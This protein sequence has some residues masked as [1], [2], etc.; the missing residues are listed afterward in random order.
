MRLLVFTFS[1]FA[2]SCLRSC[3]RVSRELEH[4]QTSRW[5]YIL[6]SEVDARDCS[7]TERF[8]GSVSLP[9]LAGALSART[10]IRFAPMEENLAPIT[11]RT[12]AWGGLSF[13]EGVRVCRRRR[14]V[15]TSCLAVDGLQWPLLEAHDRSGATRVCDLDGF[16][17]RAK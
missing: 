12:D 13:D 17:T 7:G 2:L 4:H 8:T 9:F 1:K 3:A 10:E 5:A 15:T 14:E 16:A 6:G 11:K